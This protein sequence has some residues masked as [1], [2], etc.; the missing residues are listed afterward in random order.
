M[1]SIF[2]HRSYSKMDS[3]L[4]WF[5]PNVLCVFTPN[6]PL[7]GVGRGASWGFIVA[8]VTVSLLPAEIHCHAAQA[9]PA[10]VLLGSGLSCPGSLPFSRF[11]SFF[12]YPGST[13][14]F[15][16]PF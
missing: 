15:F 11:S 2:L 4:C 1:V 9:G 5:D 16:F 7:C 8:E 10:S 3:S 12:F 13:L 14:Q 6:F